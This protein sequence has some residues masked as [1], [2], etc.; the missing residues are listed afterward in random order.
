MSQ[1][2]ALNGLLWIFSQRNVWILITLVASVTLH[3]DIV[4]VIAETTMRSPYSVSLEA[5]RDTRAR[6]QW[7]GHHHDDGIKAQAF[8]VCNCFTQTIWVIK[9]RFNSY[10]LFKADKRPWYRWY[11]DDDG[12][13][14]IMMDC[15]T[16]KRQGRGVLIA[17]RCIFIC[18][19]IHSHRREVGVMLRIVIITSCAIVLRWMPQNSCNDKVTWVIQLIP[20]FHYLSHTRTIGSLNGLRNSG[21]LITLVNV[22]PYI[23]IYI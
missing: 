4:A 13:G 6:K 7:R 11:G 1:L 8:V 12:R 19:L 3:H 22:D 20:L 10:F 17:K 18:F 21:A 23:Y 9:H 16:M 15:I 2:L 14:G 5:L